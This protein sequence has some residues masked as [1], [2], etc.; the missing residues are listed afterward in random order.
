M[1]PLA[2]VAPLAAVEH[3]EPVEFVEHVEP[4]EPV[5]H[6]EPVKQNWYLT[7]HGDKKTNHHSNRKT[8]RRQGDQIITCVLI[9]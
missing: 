1:A 2:H 9:L 4:V 3:V 5:E 8:C 7:S 6:V